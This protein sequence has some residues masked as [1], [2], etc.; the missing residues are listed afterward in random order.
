M[1]VTRTRF[2]RHLSQRFALMGAGTSLAILLIMIV[3][4]YSRCRFYD[5]EDVLPNHCTYML[6]DLV[7]WAGSGL[8]T[9]VIVTGFWPGLIVRI[10]NWLYAE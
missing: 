8:L 10:R 2:T 7:F 3:F 9:Y 5:L 1:A 6:Y 4:Q